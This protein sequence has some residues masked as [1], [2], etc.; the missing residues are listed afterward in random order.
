MAI[1][2][3]FDRFRITIA[4]LFAPWPR[5]LF[6]LFLFSSFLFF[7]VDFV[8]LFWTFLIGALI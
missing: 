5:H 3:F 7:S 4:F 2:I 1:F 6:F 8:S